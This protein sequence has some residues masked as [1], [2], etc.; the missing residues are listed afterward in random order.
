M[1]MTCRWDEWVPE[2]RIIKLNEQGFIKRRNLLEAQ[3]KKNRPQSSA[4]TSASPPPTGRNSTTRAKGKASE[5]VGRKR[6]RESVAETVC[7][8]AGSKRTTS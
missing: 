5:P 3:T 8:A 2:A 1:L 6:Q 7:A 4:G